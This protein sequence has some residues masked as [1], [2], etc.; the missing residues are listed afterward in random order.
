MRPVHR[1]FW[2]DPPL[3]I[4]ALRANRQNGS[5]T[6]SD[7]FTLKITVPSHFHYLANICSLE[8]LLLGSGMLRIPRLDAWN[9]LHDRYRL[10]IRALRN[11]LESR[12]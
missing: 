6:V 12:P 5:L 9:I 2:V 11:H 1:V 10:S 8:N 7:G 4:R 3:T